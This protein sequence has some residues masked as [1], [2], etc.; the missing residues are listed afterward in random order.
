MLG[1]AVRRVAP[2]L[3]GSLVAALLAGPA[4]GA[5]RPTTTV[6]ILRAGVIAAHDVPS[7]W[8]STPRSTAAAPFPSGA[9][10]QTL[11]AVER[12]ARRHAPHASS[13]QFSDPQS[14]NTT[15]ADDSVYAFTSAA[16]AHRYLAAYQAGG[17]SGCFQ[18]V[19][20]DAVGASGTATIAPLTAQLVG[21]G[22]ENAG[23]EGTVQGANGAG[24]AVALVADIVAVRVGRAVAVFEFLSANRQITAGPTIVNTVVQRLGVR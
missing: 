3:L 15:Q 5:A 22:D 24:Q 9:A 2:L 19:L 8:I 16:A 17:A 7:T 4:A 13:P 23:Y 18:L 21:L 6:A 14:G 12:T 20:T 10:C 1:R 11:A